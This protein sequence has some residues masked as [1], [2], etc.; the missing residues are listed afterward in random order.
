MCDVRHIP[1]T[2][3]LSLSPP[4]SDNL[5]M[6]NSHDETDVEETEVVYTVN[7]EGD[8]KVCK[9]FGYSLQSFWLSAKFSVVCNL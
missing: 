7:R 5:V 4:L 8:Y 3:S 6:I 2:S 9:V 1:W